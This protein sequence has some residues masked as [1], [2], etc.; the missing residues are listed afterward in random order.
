MYN[1][2][3]MA[4]FEDIRSCIDMLHENS[5]LDPMEAFGDL[6]L[7]AHQRAALYAC[8]Q[9]EAG[10][11]RAPLAENVDRL[12]ARLGAYCD[13]PGAGKSAVMLALAAQE[14]PVLP[15]PVRCHTLCGGMM[16]FLYHE[17]RQAL[18]C[19]VIVVPHVVVAQWG[20]YTEQ[21]GVDAMMVSKS[22]HF[23]NFA[24]KLE[25]ARIII[26]SSTFYK[27]LVMR[28]METMESSFILDRLIVDEADSICLGNTPLLPARMVWAVTG[29]LK[30]MLLPQTMHRYDPETNRAVCVSSGIRTR[31]IKVLFEDLAR[32]IAIQER[33]AIF[34]VSDTS[35]VNS[36]L[37]LPL[38]DVRYVRCHTPYA[39]HM[40]NGLVDRN[41]MT[42]L[43][44]D[45]VQLALS[46]ISNK[47]DEVNIVKLLHQRWTE[48]IA[49]LETAII[50]LEEGGEHNADIVASMRRKV[51]A[52][53]K[54]ADSV[55]ER[56]NGADSMCGVCFEETMQNMTITPCCANKYCFACVTRW[57]AQHCTCPSC[58]ASCSTGDLHVVVDQDN[59]ETPCQ[60]VVE[61]LG[62][63]ESCIQLVMA[64]AA[65]PEARVLVC[66]TNGGVFSPICEALATKG[67]SSGTIK[68]N[69]AAIR[70]AITRFR[71]GD[72]QAMFV[73]NDG[74]C[75]GINLE[76]VTDVIIYSRFDEATER[77]VISRAQRFTRTRSLRVHYLVHDNELG[78][79]GAL[80][81]EECIADMDL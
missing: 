5:P 50:N 69:S 21:V 58:R 45:D 11:C 57:V 47:G 44:T 60:D 9:I 79:Q 64:L 3:E 23:R 68:G 20:E 31:S 18:R 22:A 2:G 73:S 12:N 30:N 62:K 66:C 13:C 4:D 26:V 76:F 78:S 61:L 7:R 41:I 1:E 70:A 32:G 27:V 28:L 16:S 77:Q 8:K 40:L 19:T 36:C 6:R 72:V 65:D 25:A 71:D 42:A 46:Y 51:V 63:Q 80:P 14:S 34:V 81:V 15:N 75:A 67:V 24:S 35:F 54:Q 33:G 48:T 55:Q 37:L 59:V 38:P 56:V 29:S 53:Q 52:H 49:Q 74:Y 43:H 10:L 39:V 17:T